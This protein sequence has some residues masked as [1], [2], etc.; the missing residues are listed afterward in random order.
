MLT[1]R[2]NILSW[3]NLKNMPCNIWGVQVDTHVSKN[4][5]DDSSAW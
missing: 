3:I 2:K 1:E 4:E 5:G